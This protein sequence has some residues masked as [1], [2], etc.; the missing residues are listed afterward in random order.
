VFRITEE[1][2][3]HKKAASAGGSFTSKLK[4]FVIKFAFKT[5][6]NPSYPAAAT[7]SSVF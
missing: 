2:I 5:S 1:T 6:C 3:H 4:N 7:S